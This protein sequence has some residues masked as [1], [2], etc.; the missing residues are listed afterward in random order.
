[1]IKIFLFILMIKFTSILSLCHLVDMYHVVPLSAPRPKK[2]F[3][4]HKIF[5]FPVNAADETIVFV[6]RPKVQLVSVRLSHFLNLFT[7]VIIEIVNVTCMS[8]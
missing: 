6:F 2:D 7:W 3:K 1:M 8:K 4:Y 5:A